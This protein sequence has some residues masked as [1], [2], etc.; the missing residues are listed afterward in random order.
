[1][2]Q[3][4]VLTSVCILAVAGCAGEE[5]GTLVEPTA[6]PVTASVGQ[7]PVAL[8]A[9]GYR[10]TVPPEVFG[11][12]VGNH[13]VFNAKRR[14]DGTESGHYQYDQTFLGEVFSFA[15]PV[16]CFQVYDGNRAKIGGV[17]ATT[18]DPTIPVGTFL[19][20][21]VIDNGEGATSAP[22]Q[23]TI[24]GAGDEAANEAFC[25]SSALPRFGPWDVMKGN[26]QV[27]NLP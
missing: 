12:E 1:M 8:A 24:V 21:S 14:S 16:T 25:N 18:N 11:A 15:G 7:A 19:W 13:F 20:W 10:F 5:Q 27:R 26:A 4:Y 2:S 22:D 9:G 3:R 23:S 6:L 17:V